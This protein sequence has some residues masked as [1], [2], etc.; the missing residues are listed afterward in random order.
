MERRWLL[1]GAGGAGALLGAFVMVGMAPDTGSSP[2]V[3]RAVAPQ[4]PA[5]VANAPVVEP[6]TPPA[7]EVLPGQTLEEVLSGA[8]AAKPELRHWTIDPSTGN[9]DRP[10]GE[11]ALVIPPEGTPLAPDVL[12]LEQLFHQRADALRPCA[13]GAPRPNDDR[14]NLMV[15]ITL[16]STDG[17]TSIGGL[18]IGNDPDNQFSGVATCVAGALQGANFGPMPDPRPRQVSWFLK[19]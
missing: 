12:G 9:P 16:V 4:A 8:P 7:P 10:K 19:L 1:L 3:E 11:P 13:E 17:K 14:P 6:T 15:V 5:P 18:Q 2:P